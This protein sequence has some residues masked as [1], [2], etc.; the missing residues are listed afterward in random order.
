M[1]GGAP[2]FTG[3]SGK[4]LVIM[5][6]ETLGKQVR[7]RRGELGL[8][9]TDVTARGGPSVEKLRQIENNRAGR[10]SALMRGA[11]ERALEW[12]SGSVD[13]I[14]AGGVPTPVQPKVDVPLPT[15]RFALAR[16]V[17]SL[18]ATF[19]AHRDGIEPA[20]RE[21]LMEQITRS[22]RE[23]EE[24]IIKLMPWL[25]D[26]ERGEAIRLLGELRAPV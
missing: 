14:L 22:A 19:A 25:D 20:A 2:I 21:A 26:A 24:S 12:E 8:T 10:L 11:L 1:G 15:D 4:M 18:R 6:W 5:S 16:E 3:L 23:A 7:E 9:Q 13:A 17:L